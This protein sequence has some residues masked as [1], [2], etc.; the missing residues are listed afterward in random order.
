MFGFIGGIPRRVGNLLSRFR[1]FFSKPQYDNFRRTMLGLITAGKGEHDVKSVNELFIERKDQSSMNRF[2]TDPRWNLEA[3]VKEG[4]ALLLDEMSSLNA[5]VEYKSID[6][7]VCKKY[8][9][10]TEMVCY[11][12]SSTMGTVLSHD[13]VT[14]LYV[15]G[16]AAVP[17]GLKLYGSE[18]KCREKEIMFKTKV[19][20][21]CEIID[22]HTPRAETTILLWDSWYM[23]SDVV[24][25]CRSH[26]YRWIGEIKS[27]RIVLYEGKK[28]HLN[29]LVDL[30]RAEGRFS[31]VLVDG[32]IYQ[33]CKVEAFV[34]SLGSVSIVINVKADT[35][36]IHLLCTDLTHCSTEEVVRHVLKRQKIEEFHKGAKYLGLGE[37]RFRESEAALIHAHL[38]ALAYTLLDTLRRRLVRYNLM[39]TLPS[40]EATVEWV[41]RGAAHLFIHRIRNAKIP[42]R[43]ILRMIDT[44]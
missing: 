34:P 38:V 18:K 10:Y 44:R 14:S 26:R 3:V 20:L 22:E 36:D 29:E 31:D 30:L 39:K 7:T 2:I 43:N 42:I 1:R 4:R 41:R 40:L 23:C 6:D 37:Y 5:S 33:A 9:P 15:N 24:A 32:A 27:N 19:Q 16:D 12:H 21:A 28:Y 17:E 25:R 35:K 8:S 13:Y 11:N